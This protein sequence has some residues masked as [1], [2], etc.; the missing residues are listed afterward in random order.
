MSIQRQ[1]LSMEGID[2]K[3]KSHFNDIEVGTSRHDACR[4]PSARKGGVMNKEAHNIA[5]K[6]TPQAFNKIIKQDI[7]WLEGAICEAEKQAS[8]EFDHIKDALRY[9]AEQYAGQQKI[10]ISK[11]G[12]VTDE[13]IEIILDYR[14]YEQMNEGIEDEQR[15]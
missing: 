8:L 10:L 12:R 15:D 7:N 2:K 9:A 14:D 11:L 13:E 6:M 5:C 1:M 3:A 4:L